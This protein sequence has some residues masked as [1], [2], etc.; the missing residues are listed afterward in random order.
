MCWFVFK[1]FRREFC[2]R[3][4][5]VL[6]KAGGTYLRYERNP[7][8]KR[9]VLTE[10]ASLRQ[11]K[12]KQHRLVWHAF[13]QQI[14]E[15]VCESSAFGIVL[16]LIT[17]SSEAFRIVLELS[18]GLLCMCALLLEPAPCLLPLLFH[19]LPL[20]QK[21]IQPLLKPPLPPP[22]PPPSTLSTFSVSPKRS[23]PRP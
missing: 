4:R 10:L 14:L 15:I 8:E 16:C 7:A 22:P 23:L 9:W 11:Q 19:L 13:A 5:C 20:L 3:L 1:C 2:A 21:G 18:L 17:A 6:S 12:R